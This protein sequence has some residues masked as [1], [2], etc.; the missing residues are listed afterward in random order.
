MMATILFKVNKNRR[1]SIPV[2]SMA[3]QFRNIK[4]HKTI[5]KK[6]HTTLLQ[7]MCFMKSIHS[8]Q[9]CITIFLTV[10]L[11]VVLILTK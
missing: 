9:C 5:S 8:D 3:F 10:V 1:I 4:I 2:Q 11:L 6:K 7:T